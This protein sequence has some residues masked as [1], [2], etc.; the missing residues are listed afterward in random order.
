MCDNEDEEDDDATARMSNCSGNLD[1]TPSEHSPIVDVVVE[2]TRRLSI[3]A[4]TQ[5][6]ALQALFEKENE[7][8]QKISTKRLVSNV[9]WAIS[10]SGATGHFVVEGA[11]VINKQ[12][13]INPIII[14]LP[15]GS[16]T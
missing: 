13:A 14:T 7:E 2:S 4:P 6:K 12:P 8:W 15:S 5:H 10:D 9:T 16:T 1:G 11:P 3:S